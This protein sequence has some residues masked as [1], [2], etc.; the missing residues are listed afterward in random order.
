MRKP[1]SGSQAWT[2]VVGVLAIAAIAVAE[3]PKC[4]CPVAA[5]AHEVGVPILSNVPYINRLFKNVG[6]ATTP[7]ASGECAVAGHC[8]QAKCVEANGAVGKCESGKCPAVTTQVFERIGID[9]DVVADAK[10]C[11]GGACPIGKLVACD[12]ATGCKAIAVAA[13]AGGSQSCGSECCGCKTCACEEKVAASACPF[14]KTVA[15]TDALWEKIVELSAGQA[16]AEAALEVQEDTLDRTAEM[17]EA[18]AEVHAEKARLEAKL[19][20]QE[21]QTELLGKLAEMAA[22]NAQLKAQVELAEAKAKV[23]EHTVEITVENE[24]LKMRLAEIEKQPEGRAARTAAKPRTEKKA[25]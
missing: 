21:G 1:V 13:K 17:L 2:V 11:E 7:C 16:A 15:K 9:F 6:I 24:R 23:M 25:R 8:D 19:E 5:T 3:E 20:L 10:Q 12:V 14:A 4:Q 22:E 18:L